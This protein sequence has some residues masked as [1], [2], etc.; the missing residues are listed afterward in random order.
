QIIDHYLQLL[1]K[2]AAELAQG[3]QHGEW[4]LKHLPKGRSI[5]L[6]LLVSQAQ[7]SLELH[8]KAYQIHLVQL[9]KKCKN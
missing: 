6:V 9:W 3:L 4:E 5:D 7:A 2:L 1:K 8:Q